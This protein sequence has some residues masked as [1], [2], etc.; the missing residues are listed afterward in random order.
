MKKFLNAYKFA[1]VSVLFFII[2]IFVKPELK[3]EMAAQLGNNLKEMFSIIP[4]I[5]ILLGL[6]DVWVEKEAIMKYMGENSGL[7]GTLLTFFMATAAA[8][9]LFIA[10]PIAVMLLKKGVKLFNFY[11]FL[12]VWSCA[13][14]PYLLFETAN[15]GVK[16]MLIRFVF[17]II[18]V[19][20]MAIILAKTTSAEDRIW[21][22]QSMD[23]K[24]LLKQ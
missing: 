16:Y 6:L 17:N 2:V 20:I 14:I 15:M 19:S 9:P 21:M 13:K 4:A 24:N 3:Q 7:L 22:I 10:F 11:F 5:F 1:I 8:G 23:N 18:G 12:G